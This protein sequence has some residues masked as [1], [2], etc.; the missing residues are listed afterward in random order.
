MA[1]CTGNAGP[2]GE[3]NKMPRDE[4]VQQWPEDVQGQQVLIC[5]PGKGREMTGKNGDKAILRINK[6]HEGGKRIA[7]RVKMKTNRK[8]KTVKDYTEQN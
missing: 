2:V 7:E 8:K 4:S 6:K 5:S 3:R 1:V